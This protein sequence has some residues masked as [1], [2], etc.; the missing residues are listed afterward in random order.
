MGNQHDT[1]FLNP[2]EV[3]DESA[4]KEPMLLL[5][6][7]GSMNDRTSEADSTPRRDTIREAIGII[8]STLAKED[9]QAEHEESGG[10]LRTVTFAG[11]KA[12]DLDDINPKNL[13]EKWAKIHWEGGTYIMP[14]WKK[15]LRVYK[16]EFGKRPAKERPVLM[17]LVITDGEASDK[18]QFGATL[19]HL[20]GAVFVTVAIIGFGRDHDACLES[21]KA[22]AA[23]NPHVRV[24]A[25]ASETNPEVIAAALLKMIT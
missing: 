3:P 22:I 14:G 24:L 21:Y 4:E 16:E 10:G 5:D 13:K 1:S 17:A 18:D 19:S 25:F 12:R 2:E 9:S 15:L 11:G 6:T 23:E 8:V 20:K 7:T